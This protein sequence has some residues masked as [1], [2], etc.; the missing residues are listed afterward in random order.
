MLYHRN[1]NYGKGREGERERAFSSPAQNQRNVPQPPPSF[2][3]H[4]P[5]DMTEPL[6]PPHS[7]RADEEEDKKIPVSCQLTHETKKKKGR[8]STERAGQRDIDLEGGQT[9]SSSSLARYWEGDDEEGGEGERRVRGRGEEEEEDG[10]TRED[11]GHEEDEMSRTLR[12]TIVLFLAVN[13]MCRGAIA[14]VESHSSGVDQTCR[15]WLSM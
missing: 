6:L 10:R 15:N 8:E 14:V 5:N 12:F 3:N 7:M 11:A 13:M 9:S 1:S 4:S 2:S